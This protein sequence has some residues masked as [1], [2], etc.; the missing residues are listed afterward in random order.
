MP[1]PGRS[2]R[3]PAIPLALAGLFLSS[4]ACSGLSFAAPTATPTESPTATGTPTSTATPTDTLTPTV[5]ATREP[6]P[7]PTS[8]YLDWPIL[9]S[10]S[11]D[12]DYGGWYTGKT[13][14]D[15]FLAD[16]SITGGKYLVKITSK[17]SFFW[18]LKADTENLT[19]FYLSA[20]VKRNKSPD[21]TDFGLVFHSV[22]EEYYYFSI[23]T[24]AKQYWVVM[25]QDNDW[26]KIVSWKYAES[27][28]PAGANQLAV[29]AQGSK[30][31]LFLNGKEIDSFEDDTLDRGRAGLGLELYQAGEFLEIEFDNFTVTAPE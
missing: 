19:D 13:E 28:D 4:L 11:F 23:N 14:N 27:I 29:L 5:K 10:D 30:F 6:T 21:K 22:E 16:V 1:Q 3:F 9:F 15:Y 18:Q 25:H 12:A 7:A 8:S 26:V 31:T 17:K 20:E 24:A 2:S